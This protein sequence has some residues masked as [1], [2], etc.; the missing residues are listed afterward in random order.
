M[1]Y[2]G[3]HTY[4]WYITG[5]CFTYD[6]SIPGISWFSVCLCN[7]IEKVDETTGTTWSRGG[8]RKHPWEEHLT[9]KVYTTGNKVWYMTS[10]YL[11]YLISCTLPGLAGLGSVPGRFRPGLAADPLS[12]SDRKA[13]NSRLGPAKVPQQGVDLI[14][15][16]SPAGS[17]PWTVKHT[18]TRRPVSVEARTCA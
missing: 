10:I 7:Y 9:Q 12:F 2:G 15:M 8:H 14:N 13:S 5:L 18:Q 4:W 17:L 3:K 11:S 16:T 6:R 1:L